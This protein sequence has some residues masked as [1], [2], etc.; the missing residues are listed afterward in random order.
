[1][2]HED[3]QR[4]P[5]HQNCVAFRAEKRERHR[6]ARDRAYPVART[7]Q[8]YPDRDHTRAAKQHAEAG[9]DCDR[10]NHHAPN[11]MVP[12]AKS[13]FQD[14]GAD[15]ARSDQGAKT[16]GRCQR[17]AA[18]LQQ[19]KNVHRHNGHHHGRERQ[20]SRQERKDHPVLRADAARSRSSAD[21]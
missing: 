19:R 10:G 4:Q 1:M 11:G 17:D 16:D 15:L 12:S 8:D 5:A 21:R 7:V 20:A 13:C 2:R 6:S 3:G 14:S 9:S 18:R